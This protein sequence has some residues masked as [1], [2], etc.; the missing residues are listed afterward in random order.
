METQPKFKIGD[1]VKLKSSSVYM[2]VE[3]TT[4]QI[5]KEHEI[6]CVWFSDDRVMRDTFHSETLVK[7]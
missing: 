2:T 4:V 7:V 5:E 6:G 1:L 3:T